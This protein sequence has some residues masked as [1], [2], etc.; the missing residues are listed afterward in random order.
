M[1]NERKRLQKLKWK[2]I[3]ENCNEKKIIYIY[4][5]IT[6]VGHRS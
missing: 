5:E 3:K 2:K 4:I 6:Y 1:D